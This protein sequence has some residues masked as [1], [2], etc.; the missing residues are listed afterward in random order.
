MTCSNCLY[1][2]VCPLGLSVKGATGPCS[3]FKNK[4]DLV[5]VVRCEKC[6]HFRDDT[7]Y[8]QSHKVGYCEFD[9]LIKNKKHYC[10]YGD[11]REA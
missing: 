1:Y 6:I 5:K 3:K 4:A 9:N 7:E 2:E 11:A 8:C 10:G